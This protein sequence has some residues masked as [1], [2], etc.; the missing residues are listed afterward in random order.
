MPV[1]ERFFH[2]CRL[3]LGCVEHQVKKASREGNGN[4]FV[5]VGKQLVLR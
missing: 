4:N 2:G 3:C 5:L 1:E